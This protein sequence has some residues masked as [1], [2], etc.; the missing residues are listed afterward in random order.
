M[1]AHGQLVPPS[2]IVPSQFAV[3]RESFPLTI[4]RAVIKHFASTL[5][6]A[7]GAVAFLPAA[8]REL[9][10]RAASFADS[11]GLPPIWNGF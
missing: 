9:Q 2:L 6:A 5:A 10:S 7:P 1:L 4:S 11:V 8:L 3:L